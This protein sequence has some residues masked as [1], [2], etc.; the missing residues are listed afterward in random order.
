MPGPESPEQVGVD[1]PEAAKDADET[2]GGDQGSGGDGA[3]DEEN[4]NGETGDGEDG[5]EGEDEEEQ[6]TWV[7]FEVID[8]AGNPCKNEK[9]IIT[10]PDESTKE[11]KTD[12]QGVVKVEDIDRGDGGKV[13]IQLKDRYDYEWAFK[14][15]KDG[16]RS[17]R[18]AP[19]D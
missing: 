1:D 12:G 15:V 11:D 19:S 9:V 14:E 18:S 13:A 3:D 8:A 6:K 17:T 2:Q 5:N 7:E 4:G 16:E 10:M